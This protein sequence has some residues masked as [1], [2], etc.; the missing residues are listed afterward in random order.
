MWIKSGRVTLERFMLGLVEKLTM[1]LLLYLYNKQVLVA[2]LV[3]DHLLLKD[4][5]HYG[6]IFRTT[7]VYYF[8]FS[9]HS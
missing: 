2:W 7:C 5:G 8:R 3:G 1:Y 6:I 9:R 4:F